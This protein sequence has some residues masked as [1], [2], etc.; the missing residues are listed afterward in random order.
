MSILRSRAAPPPC[1]PSGRLRDGILHLPGHKHKWTP[2]ASRNNLWQ[3]ELPHA[4]K[5]WGAESLAPGGWI[6]TLGQVPDRCLMTLPNISIDASALEIVAPVTLR[7]GGVAWRLRSPAVMNS[8]KSLLRNPDEM[9]ADQKALLHD[10]FLVTIGRLPF[11][12]GNEKIRFLLRRTNYGKPPA[13]WRDLFRIAAPMRAF[14][15][16]LRFGH[17]GVSTP[18]VLAAGIVRRWHLPQTGYLLVEEINPA[19]TLGQRLRQSESLERPVI[20]SIGA[21]I[22]GLHEQGGFHGDLTINNILLD[23]RGHPWFID[24]E[25]AQFH[26]RALPWSRSVEDF[27]RFARHYVKLSPGARGTAMRIMS[28][29]CAERGWRKRTREFAEAVYTRARHKIELPP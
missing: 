11:T 16:A 19:M 18:R 24:L 13:V 10:T 1:G 3:F 7:V 21:A 4:W 23:A 29:Y 14:R 28:A 9:L 27:H 12:A 15:N 25:R 22:A 8:L 26:W 6:S 17:L 20:Q 2:W 5:S